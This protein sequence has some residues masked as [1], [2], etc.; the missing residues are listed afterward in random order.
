[1]CDVVWCGFCCC[2]LCAC[3]FGLE[4]DRM[5]CLCCCLMCFGIVFVIYC[6]MSYDFFCAD[7]RVCVFVC[8]CVCLC[9]CLLYC[10]M[11]Y[12][13]HF[14]V[15]VCLCVRVRLNVFVCV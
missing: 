15:V 10:V 4:A 2:V 13:C 9:F 12:G 5:L 8:V 3:G 14:C 6:V 1:M 7:S 11:L